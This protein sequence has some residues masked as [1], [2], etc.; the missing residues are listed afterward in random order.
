MV[1]DGL[2]SRCAFSGRLAEYTYGASEFGEVMATV[3][4]ITSG[5][6]DSWYDEWNG[7]A[8]RVFA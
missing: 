8:E 2:I 7:T 4:R 3:N 1:G 5:N 6:H